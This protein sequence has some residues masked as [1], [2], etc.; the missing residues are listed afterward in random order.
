MDQFAS[1][2]AD[3]RLTQWSTKGGCGCKIAPGELST[4]LSALPKRDRHPN[5]LVGFETNDDA[6]VYRLSADSALVQ[7][8]DFFTPIVDRPYDFG[9]IAAANALSDVYAMGGEP[10]TALNLVGFP[11]DQLD[12]NILADILRGA[13]DKVAEAGATIVG[14]HSI[15]DREPKFGLA[16]T[17]LVHPDRVWTNG[18][19]RAGDA[20]I[21]T[22]PIGVGIMSSAL[23]QGK[24]NEQQIERVTGVMA[25]LNKYA[26]DVLR[27]H[28]V[29]ACTDVTG[30]GLLGHALEMAR[31][32]G[33]T[34]RIEQAIVPV[35]EGAGDLATAG[36]IPGGSKKNMAHVV[37]HVKFAEQLSDSERIVLCDAVTSGGLLV[38][39]AEP[40]SVE[41]LAQLHAAGVV[42]A[43]RIGTVA[44]YDGR[45]YIEVWG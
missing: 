18:G 19:A 1:S 20:L 32:S 35:L 26:A 5:L 15:D 39:V 40:A 10:L 31:A 17:G 34:I 6:G 9:Q 3:V 25:M 2:H 43:T 38:A 12:K 7:T 24:L 13:S 8:V 4:I 29:H 45:H 16:V 28:D 36:V 14:G 23:K 11:V 44:E 21:L 30:F 27:T 22:K 42:W 37:P 33:M 41:I